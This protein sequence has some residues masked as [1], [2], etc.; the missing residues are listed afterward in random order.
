MDQQRDYEKLRGGL[1]AALRAEANEAKLGGGRAGHLGDAFHDAAAGC[2]FHTDAPPHK[3]RGALVISLEK[4][5]K[6]LNFREGITIIAGS[7]DARMEAF[8]LFLASDGYDDL[9][10]KSE[11]A[12]VQN[13]RMAD[14]MDLD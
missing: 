6:L 2:T 9:P 12:H 13:V 11:R 7:Y 14:V 10:C 4:L 8:E 5:A 1:G 3:R